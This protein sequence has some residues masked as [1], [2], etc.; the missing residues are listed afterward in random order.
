MDLLVARARELGAV[1]A[2]RALVLEGDSRISHRDFAELAPA[3]AYC[4][5]AAA[6]ADDAPPIAIVVDREFRIV[7][8][9]RG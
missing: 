6:E 5:D 3:A 8:R 9:G 1:A 2:Y 7:H 4:D